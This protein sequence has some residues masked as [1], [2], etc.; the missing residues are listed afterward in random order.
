MLND[1]PYL[2]AGEGPPLV[3]LLYTPQAANPRGLARWSTMRLVRPFTEHFTVY[4]VNRRP[5]LPPGTTM[6]DLAHRARTP[7]QAAEP[8]A[9]RGRHGIDDRPKA[10]RRPDVAV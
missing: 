8:R 10:A 2:S 3:V 6:T 4:V 9:G 5:G 7:R 1:L